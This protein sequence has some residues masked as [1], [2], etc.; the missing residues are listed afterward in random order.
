MTMMKTAEEIEVVN[1]PV[2]KIRCR[3]RL[4]NPKESKIRE[5][6]ESIE[7]LGLMNPITID[8]NNYLI[9]GFHR[10]HSYKLLERETIP[11]IIK[12]TTHVYGEL[13]EIDENLKRNE[14]N[15]LEIAEHMVRR[16]ELLGELGIRMKNGGNQYTEGQLVTTTELAKEVGMTNRVYRLKRQP[17]SIEEEVKDILRETVWAENL[18]DMVKLS[19]QK[20]EIQLEIANLLTTGKCHT[21]KRALCEANI[22]DWN[23]NREYKVSFD[24]KERWGIPQTIMRFKKSDV[25]LQQL[26]DLVSKDHNLEWTKR[27]G[28]HF[29][30][31]H[32]PVYQMAADHAEFLVTYY[33]P[34]EGI[35]LDSFMGR[36][37]IGLAALNTG[38]KFIGYDVE[39]KNVDRMREVVDKHMKGVKDNCTVYHSNGVVLDELK[40]ESNYLSAVIQDPPY[41]LKAERYTDDPRDISSLEHEEYMLKIRENFQQVYRLIKKSNFEKKEF[42]PVIWKVGTG[43]RGKEG[44]VDMDADFQWIGKDVGF[45]LWDKLYNQLTSPWAAVNWERNYVNRYVQKNYE[46]NLVFCKF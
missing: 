33:T 46:T 18:M 12:D 8:S 1:V 27:D 11:C 43:R 36:G 14:L 24:L 42:Y 5:I 26:C 29:G 32:I 9:A 25:E 38:R 35:I 39:K 10:L 30:T 45:V 40:D 23:S 41:C 44:I 3:F 15:H 34:E 16:E 19:Q 37:T 2:K 21:F 4:R 6:A 22:Q 31:S 7:Q 20:P 13:M 28:I 17:A